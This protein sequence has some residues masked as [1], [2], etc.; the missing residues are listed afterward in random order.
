MSHNRHQISP[1]PP[2]P[3]GE[4]FLN[5]ITGT[6][7]TQEEAER[8][9][10]QEGQQTEEVNAH[11]TLHHHHIPPRHSTDGADGHVEIP[12][13]PRNDREVEKTL[14]AAERSTDAQ[15]G[16]KG[17]TRSEEDKPDRTL[18][19]HRH[20]D[21]G[22]GSTT[23]P[24]VQEGKE[25]SSHHSSSHR[26]SHHSVVDDQDEKQHVPDGYFEQPVHESKQRQQ[27]EK[28]PDEP[29]YNEEL[30]RPGNERAS[31]D[32]TINH[33]VYYTVTAKDDEGEKEAYHMKAPLDSQTQDVDD[34]RPHS[35]KRETHSLLSKLGHSWA[36][37][38]MKVDS[39]TEQQ[40]PAE[41]M[42]ER[43]TSK[44]PRIDSGIIPVLTPLVRDE[45]I[46]LAR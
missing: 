5:F 12:P 18:L 37:R 46:G 24:I 22:R 15:T 36:N 4:R 34:I 11:N 44:P 21:E 27:P 31:Q 30:Q 2:H 1:I 3:Y 10:H 40:P 9:A 20:A 7:M 23:L 6:T 19:T 35:P 14:E 25:N 16:R 38:D 43:R 45:E 13:H 8:R 39:E 26:N 32:H 28:S 41:S 29:E 33:S 42:Y 17:R